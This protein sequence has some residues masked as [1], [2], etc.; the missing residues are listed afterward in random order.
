MLLDLR[1]QTNYNKQYNM[2]KELM[3][4]ASQAVKYCLLH[5]LI[6]PRELETLL[7]DPKLLEET[8]KSRRDQHLTQGFK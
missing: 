4:T 3:K 7:K 8:S 1:L 6:T 5:N 2:K